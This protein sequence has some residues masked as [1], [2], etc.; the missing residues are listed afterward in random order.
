MHLGLAVIFV[1]GYGYTRI[2]SIV[3]GHMQLTITW[4]RRRRR[5]RRIGPGN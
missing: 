1:E 4:R 2:D 3:P 5:R